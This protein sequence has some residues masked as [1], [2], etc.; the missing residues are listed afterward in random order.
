M[1]DLAALHRS[2]RVA[3]HGAS[4]AHLRIA[5]ATVGSDSK[6][7]RLL[8][9]EAFAPVIAPLV[10]RRVGYVRPHGHVGDALI[11]M[12]MV[13]LFAEYGV[14]WTPLDLDAPVDVETIVFGGGGSM[15]RRSP[16]NHALRTRALALGAPVVV[17]P[18][19]F[20]DRE[21]RPFAK[22]F[23]RERASLGLCPTATLA[24][25]LA[26]GLACPTPPAPTQ[27]LGIFLRRDQERTGR[28]LRLARDSVE[29]CRRPEELLALVARYRRI[30]TDRLHC[31][32]AGL[33]AGR[34][35]TLLPNNYHKNR[36]MHETWLAGLGC[37][38]AESV[39]AALFR[40]AVAARRTAA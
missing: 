20:T 24:P 14:D 19:S 11:E 4:D 17:L 10:G 36:S 22:V 23:V 13:Q 29:L 35:V 40:E 33:H 16:Q 7:R 2:V 12:A 30:I 28:R 34:E 18:Q 5:P 26:I 1:A 37:R 6:S 38:F 32:I 31:A 21:D 3:E 39:E 27:D 25:D 9:A 15:G 8:G